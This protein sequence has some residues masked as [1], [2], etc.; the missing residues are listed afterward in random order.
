MKLSII[1]PTYNEEEYLPNLLESIKR[2]DFT[3]YEVIIA[4]ANST[5][6]TI[7]IA[8]S[9]GVRIVEGGIPSVGRNRGAEAA[10]GKVLLFLDAD[11]IMSQGY[12]K[13]ALMEFIESGVGI[14]ITQIEP[15]SDKTF[16]RVSHDF[17][18]FFMRNVESIKPHGAGCYGMITWR[19]LHELVGG[20]DEHLDFGEDTDYIEK[21]GYLGSFKVLRTPRLFV[22]TRRVE[23]EGRRNIALKY[24]KS[25]FYQF[26]GR[27]ISADEL[28]YQFG[29]SEG[30][31]RIIYGVCGE[32]MG[33]AIRSSVIIDHLLEKNDVSIFASDR[34]YQYLAGRYDD[35]YE[36][37]GF[38]TVYEANEVKN[39]QTFVKNIK[40]VPLDLG[41]NLRL[42]YNVA[43]A[44]KPDL[45]IS[46]FEFYSNLLSKI[47]RIPL[48]SLD[49]MHVIT[50]CEYDV[51][52]EFRGDRF[53]AASVVRSFIQRPRY[54]LITSY[55]FPP[56]KNPEK[57]KMFPPIIRED[58]LNLKPSIGE[59]ILVYQTSDSN[60]ELIENLKNMEDKFIIYGFFKDEK[61]DNLT[62][63]KFNEDQFFED[64]ATA[65][66]II[67]N[68]GFSLISE[69]LYLEKP[70]Y[71]IPVK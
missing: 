28:N 39:R 27:Q 52:E 9:Y 24:A 31:K 11:V 67:T 62:F 42:M 35:V 61:I 26:T 32:G 60:L 19:K 50:Q 54:Y 15:L 1:I 59:H 43:K 45:I 21:I 49:N 71:S 55:F 17:A 40:G 46:D 10:Q 51:A 30:P 29:H 70:V 12:L 20:F 44:S 8:Q 38:N 3:D 68:G 48:V 16:D 69:A 66:A 64:L 34:A 57:V 6:H 5:D 18:N 4:D 22:S 58:V 65:R 33:H 23:E 25:T 37:E 13:S 7:E 53:R 2:Q 41:H 14:A 47:L 63:K 36:I 56:V